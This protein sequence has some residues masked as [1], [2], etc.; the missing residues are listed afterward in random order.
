MSYSRLH[1][2]GD[3]TTPL[4]CDSHCCQTPYLICSLN[5]CTT[6]YRRSVYYLSTYCTPYVH[7]LYTTAYSLY[8]LCTLYIDSCT[9]F[10]CPTHVS[11]TMRTLLFAS[12]SHTIQNFRTPKVCHCCPHYVTMVTWLL[13][14][15]GTGLVL[16]AGEI[17]STGIVSHPC[18]SVRTGSALARFPFLL[19]TDGCTVFG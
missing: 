11:Y 14:A 18:C 13:F 3:Q 12:H 9:L 6:L 17:G 15:G 5:D 4:I 7:T 19:V 2:I 16:M 10:S 8:I 1:L